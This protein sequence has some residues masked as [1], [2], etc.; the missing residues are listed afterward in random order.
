MTSQYSQISSPSLGPLSLPL[1]KFSYATVA[2]DTI[3]PIPWIHLSTRGDLF[4]VF[5]T[6]RVHHSSETIQEQSRFKVLKDPE[7]M[8]RICSG[9]KHIP[10]GG[11]QPVSDK[12]IGAH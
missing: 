1:S 9:L 4:A 2:E 7:M 10:R 6:I 3:A 11:A 5:E 8:V 12:S